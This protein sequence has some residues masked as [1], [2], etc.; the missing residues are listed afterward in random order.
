MVVKR[1]LASLASSAPVPG[2]LISALGGDELAH[3]MRLDRRLRLLDSPRPAM[4]L[5][6]AGR[7]NDRLIG[8]VQALHDQMAEP[9]AVVQWTPDGPDRLATAFA[10]LVTVAGAGGREAADALAAAAVAAR[11]DLLVGRLTSSPLLL[12]DVDP[13]PWR[14]IGPWGQGGMGMTG[15]VPYGRPMPGRAKDRDG[16]ELDQ[17]LVRIGPF[18]PP[19]PEGLVLEVRLQGDVVQGVVIGD[20]PFAG[21]GAAAEPWAAPPTGASIELKPFLTSLHEPVAIADLELARACHHLRWLGR[22]L[23]VHGLTALGQRVLALAASI[24][25]KSDDATSA[26]AV[27]EV[28]ALRRKLER[29]FTLSW[30]TRGVGVLSAGQLG[31]LAGGPVVRA[32]GEERDERLADPSYLELDFEPVTGVR[33]D[34]LAR[35]RQRLREAEQSLRLAERAA[36]MTTSVTG[37][38]EAPTGPIGRGYAPSA[39]LLRTLPSLLDGMEWGDAVTTLVSLDLDLREAALTPTTSATEEAS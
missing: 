33:G 24:R 15:G 22:M 27:E 37:V 32:A 21:D 31:S 30:V 20:N 16:L 17:L 19:L 3:G 8:P 14:D 29:N 34:A 35:W 23:R 4:V 7:L 25:P 12:P 10:H 28:A 6:I 39:R 2:F 18:L 36:G 11:D 26:Q 38:A 1:A 9:R 5:M 13:N